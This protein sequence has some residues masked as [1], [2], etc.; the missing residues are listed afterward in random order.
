[1]KK[2]NSMAIL[3]FVILILIN[4]A[5]LVK[6]SKNKKN[7][8]ELLNNNHK[9]NESISEKVNSTKVLENNIILSLASEHLKIDKNSMSFS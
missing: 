7:I 3:L 1:M 8:A 2:V 6:D 9:G 5:L 4:I